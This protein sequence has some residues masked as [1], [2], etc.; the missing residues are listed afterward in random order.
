M[1]LSSLYEFQYLKYDFNIVL[2]YDMNGT[3]EHLWKKMKNIC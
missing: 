1:S 2:N 3:V